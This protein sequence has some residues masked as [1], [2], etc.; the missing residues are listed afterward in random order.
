MSDWSEQLL[1]AARVGNTPLCI[2]LLARGADIKT[3][4]WVGQSPLHW[5]AAYGHAATCIALIDCGADANALSKSHCNPL[6]L[7][8]R[9]GHLLA[10]VAL[11]ACGSDPLVKN[12]QCKT[13]LGIAMENGSVDCASV[14]RAT[15]AATTARAILQ[16]IAANDLKIKLLHK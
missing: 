5:A 3:M 4:G 7:A 16:E 8:V 1:R 6:H 11:L 9:H 15:L 12:K 10:C 2:D 13:A 14:I